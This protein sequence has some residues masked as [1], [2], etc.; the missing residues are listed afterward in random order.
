MI[1]VTIR[2]NAGIFLHWFVPEF[3]ERWKPDRTCFPSYVCVCSNCISGMFNQVFIRLLLSCAAQSIG[4]G[5]LCLFGMA[6]VAGAQN[7]PEV[8]IPEIIAKKYDDNDGLKVA[9]FRGLTTDDMGYV[10]L[11]SNNKQ[12]TVQNDKTAALIC[13]DG[14]RFMVHPL[15]EVAD[16]STDNQFLWPWGENQLI[17]KGG[18]GTPF[19]HYDILHRKVVEIQ[20]D[21][22]RLE[23]YGF[24]GY[25][26]HRLFFTIK[27]QDGT[28][29]LAYL[30]DTSVTLLFDIPERSPQSYIY[31]DETGVTL[32]SKNRVSRFNYQ[33]QL[34]REKNLTTDAGLFCTKTIRGI[35][36]APWGQ[37]GILINPTTLE[38]FPMPFPIAHRKDLDHIMTDK[39][40]N[41]IYIF[42]NNMINT[43]SEILLLTKDGTPIDL[44]EIKKQMPYLTNVYGD[45]FEASIWV[46]NYHNLY[47][48]RIANTAITQ[49]MLEAS[50]RKIYK[51]KQERLNVA[52]ENVGIFQSAY[53]KTLRFE[54]KAFDVT[55]NFWRQTSNDGLILPSEE[56]AVFAKANWPKNNIPFYDLRS[57]VVELNDTTLLATIA[58]K[59]LIINTKNWRYQPV[60]NSVPQT[61]LL[62]R[63][64]SREALIAHSA[65]LTRLDPKTGKRTDLIKGTGIISFLKD[66][67]GAWWIGSV[68][69][70]L[71]KSTLEDPIR[72]DTMTYTS[73][74]IA[75]ITAD[76]AGRL[77]LG[78]FN[79]VYVFDI[80]KR[81]LLRI[82]DDLLSDKECNRY[83][84]FFD[85]TYHRMMIGTIRGL[86]V[87]DMDKVHLI[88][89]DPPLNLSYLQYFNSSTGKMDTLN[90]RR[91]T[92]FS[93]TLDAYHRNLLVGFAPGAKTVNNSQYLYAII[94]EGANLKNIN[95]ISNGT[96]PEL[97]ISNLNAGS[98]KLLIKTKTAL[99]EKTSNY[100]AIHIRVEDFLY[101][102][103]WFIGLVFLSMCAGA[104]GWFKRLQIENIRLEKEV[105][106]RTAQ[107]QK[108]KETIEQQAT[109]LAK[110]DEMKTQFYNNISHELKTPLALI[111]SPLNSLIEKAFVTNEK[112]QYLLHLVQKNARILAERV[113]ELLELTRLENRKVLLHLNPVQVADFVADNCNI[114][115]ME[116]QNRGIG[117]SIKL[118]MEA[119]TLVFDKKKVG[120]IVQNLLANALKYCH[121]GNH[122]QV[123]VEALAARFCLKVVDNGPGIPEDQRT[124]VFNK[125]YQLSSN[126][127]ARQDPGSGIGLSLV[128]EYTVLMGGTV[129]LSPTEGGGATFTVS[130]PAY[131]IQKTMVQAEEAPQT[132]PNTTEPQTTILVVEDNVDLRQFL[133]LLL[134]EKYKVITAANGREAIRVLDSQPDIQLILSDVMMPEMDGMALLD[135]VKHHEPFHKLPFIFLTA[136]Y[137]E[138]SK[139]DA[140]RLGVDDYLNKP[141]SETELLVRI[142]RLLQNYRN[143]KAAEALP[144]EEAVE[145]APQDTIY[146]LQRMI[147]SKLSDPTFG[148]DLIASELQM[149]TRN[150]QRYMLK[151]VGMTPKEFIIEVQ[152]NQLRELRNQ[153]Q[154]LP[155]KD[156]ATMVGYTNVKYM[157]RQFF[158]RFG[159][160]L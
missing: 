80:Q 26:D 87:I 83:S 22:K 39:M 51:V 2:K 155:L 23:V 64:S 81:Q 17:I 13:Y 77:W 42:G 138:M 131:A 65:G 53:T 134:D 158:D 156:L 63:Y 27:N 114:F 148:V 113:E 48:Y 144:E 24:P 109:E 136:R 66:K 93:V 50:V 43:I 132:G 130:I 55:K 4:W 70:Y 102:R 75:T 96:N 46:F 157:S 118:V 147:R 139:L 32:L 37:P 149:S 18:L 15:P 107:L 41:T 92:T 142:D 137:N 28:F 151:E 74:P 108:D 97:Y 7:N 150:L 105:Y 88:Q 104:Y 9:S 146:V 103:W 68:D 1:S 35:E 61:Q 14:A 86:N 21:G 125:F 98:Y 52:S 145:K 49:H 120:K 128:K 20:L 72:I 12:F 115:E 6:R 126:D 47:R 112:G 154:D 160:K 10:W 78:S 133:Q 116:A 122:V 33:G 11:F 111:V 5:L 29:R 82:D 44:S 119:E 95:W 123:Q 143:R 110:L 127:S 59:I 84:A 73:A 31:P 90:F 58:D 91:E 94:P 117:L 79:G 100:L 34:Q 76:N 3:M 129:T 56:D 19:F 69:G 135:Y 16:F 141:F 152:M 62:G 57:D 38:F 40:G 99:A 140:L 67:F 71:L 45:D 89:T 36:L 124:H 8:R 121:P 85:S 153:H 54:Q 60:L 25:Y 30:K 159:Y 106:K 101:K